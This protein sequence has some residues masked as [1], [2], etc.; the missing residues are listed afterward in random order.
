LPKAG[1]AGTSRAPAFGAVVTSKG[2]VPASAGLQADDDARL[3]L[4]R[5]LSHTHP[6]A[7][8]ALAAA[9]P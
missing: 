1:E 3:A 7:R 5:N 9:Y 2:L 6:A 4:G 8:S